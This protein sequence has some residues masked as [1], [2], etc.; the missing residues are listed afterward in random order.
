[1]GQPA[2]AIVVML[3]E[4]VRSISETFV[5][6]IER[7]EKHGAARNVEFIERAVVRIQNL[8]RGASGRST[9]E[10]SAL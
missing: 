10:T 2:R 1:M 6:Q 9:A 5:P 3:P 8:Q 4:E 7:T